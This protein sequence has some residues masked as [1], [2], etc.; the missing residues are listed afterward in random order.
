MET[1]TVDKGW[2]LHKKSHLL[3]LEKNDQG[4]SFIW[5]NDSK[6]DAED[7]NKPTRILGQT[8]INSERR[9]PWCGQVCHVDLCDTEGE[10]R[11][12][13]GREELGQQGRIC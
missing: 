10:E 6:A 11:E 1:K 5:D 2:L 12:W 13:R 8:I 9:L 7:G 3:R 4:N